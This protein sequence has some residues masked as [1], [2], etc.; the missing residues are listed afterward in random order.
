MEKKRLKKFTNDGVEKQVWLYTI[1][2]DFDGR[3]DTDPFQV[4]L[5]E[6]QFNKLHG[7]CLEMKNEDDW[8]GKII[9]WTIMP[10]KGQYKG[11]VRHR[12]D[13]NRKP[14]KPTRPN[15]PS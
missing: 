14:T 13:Q 2:I 7:I 4:S 1:P 8:K 5:K 10:A 11:M 3:K 6:K 15:K 12:R 9:S